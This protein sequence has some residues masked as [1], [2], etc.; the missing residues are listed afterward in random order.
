MLLRDTPVPSASRIDAGLEGIALAAA[1]PLR[2]APV[3]AAA[4]KRNAHYRVGRE[5]IVEAAGERP[6]VRA[7]RSWLPVTARS[8]LVRLLPP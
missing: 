7:V 4:S 3:G 2:Q 1:Q 6:T 8:P 5:P